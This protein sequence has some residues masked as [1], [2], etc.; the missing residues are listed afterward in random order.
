MASS[1]S[2]VSQLLILMIRG[3]QLIISPLLSPHC[4]FNPS[5]SQYSIVV[6]YQFGLI[7]GGLL[8]IKRI[9]KCNPLHC[10]GDDPVTVSRHNYNREH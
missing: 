4:R 7:K 3:Y 5:C 1:P 9:L 10:G 2:F 6:L 8:M